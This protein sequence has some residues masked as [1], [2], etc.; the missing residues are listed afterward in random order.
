MLLSG[1]LTWNR[2]RNLFLPAHSRGMALPDDI[3]KLLLR[4]PGIWDLPELPD[5]GG[6]LLANGA[7]AESQSSSALDMGVKK[8][9]YGVNGATG[10]L[11]AGLL[12][13]AQPG[14]AVLVPRNVHRSIIYACALGNLTPVF[15]DLPFLIDRGH[16]LPPDS[17]W[18]ENILNSIKQIEDEIVAAVLVNPFYQG[19]SIDL[20]TF[21]RKLHENS[22]P[23][24]VDE[25]HGTHFSAG[26]DELP[27][28]ALSCGADLVVHSLHKSAGGLAQTAAIWLQGD[29][30]DPVVVERSIA[31]TQT[32]SPSSLLLASCESALRDL[33]SLKGK[34]KLEMRVSK[35]RE[36]FNE[37]QKKGVPLLSNQDPLKLILHTAKAGIN[38]IDA[39][40]WMISRGI[41]AELP[42]P[43]CLTFSLGLASHRGLVNDI[44]KN[45]EALLSSK[46]ERETL[47]SSFSKPPFSLL[48]RPLLSCANAWRS[49]F[50]ELPIE[51]AVGRI[52]ADLISPYPPGIPMIIPGQL[53][54]AL[55]VDWLMSQCKVWSKEIPLNIK[56]IT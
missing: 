16:Y 49:N 6:P 52:S 54:D 27:K 14:K 50:Q 4:R 19:Y 1:L 10:L 53:L 5:F 39:D 15:Y 37:L 3:K 31:C 40:N 44:C 51:Q 56:V 8:G 25:A 45:W 35:G 34:K 38:G 41:I 47:P 30:V 18:I 43:G 23:V 11:Q 32:S 55:T 48:M 13:I 28:S 2:G 7:V 24:L 12:S 9:W 21:I 46:L 22:L 20:N 29:L 17:S 33:R 42:E 26:L 36:I